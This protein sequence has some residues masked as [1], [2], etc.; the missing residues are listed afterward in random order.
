MKKISFQ[1]GSFRFHSNK[2]SEEELTA[3]SSTPF[4]CLIVL[5]WELEGIQTTHF[6]LLLS[7]PNLE[8][9]LFL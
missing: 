1:R 4:V 7:H 5:P 2:T 3:H 8:L 6:F 9:L